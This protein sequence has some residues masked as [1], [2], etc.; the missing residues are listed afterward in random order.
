MFKKKSRRELR[1][2]QIRD[3]LGDNPFLH[4]S[5]RTRKGKSYIF[6]K[7]K[8]KLN[9]LKDKEVKKLMQSFQSFHDKEIEK[10]EHPENFRNDEKEL[11]QAEQH[12]AFA[13]KTGQL[14][15]DDVQFWTDDQ[16][17]EYYHKCL[18]E[19]GMW[20]ERDEEIVD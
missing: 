4:R 16:K 15:A 6:N 20:K 8:F 17:I 3:I 11:E 10:R 7:K 12:I 13:I 18:E 14:E 5:H 9:K 1:A 2:K 19:E